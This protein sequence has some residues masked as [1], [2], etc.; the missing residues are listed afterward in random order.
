MTRQLKNS[1]YLILGTTIPAGFG[2]FFWLINTRLFKPSQIGIATMLISAMTL[3]SFLSL[4]GFDT[5]LVRFLWHSKRRN[6]KINTAMAM[7]AI[8]A[9]VLA[10][11]FIASL[12]LT[13]PKLLFM[14]DNPWLMVGFV[15]F[16]VSAAWNVL[17]DAIFLAY[18]QTIYTLVINTFFSFEKMLLPFVLFAFGASGIFAASGLASLTGCLMS[19]GAMI[20]K[21]DY[22]PK[23]TIDRQILS[24]V[25]G[26]STANYIT[27]LC[28]LLPPSVIPFIIAGYL[29]TAKAAYFYIAFTIANLLFAISLSANRS[30]F[31]EGSHASE[32]LR[33][34]VKHAIW[35]ISLLMIP[36]IA[37]VIVL[38]P[39]LLQIFGKSY[40]RDGVGFLRL[41]ALSGIAV[42]AL[43]MIGTIF[44]VKK[45]L[46]PLVV[47]SAVY[48]VTI[49]GG[50]FI[51]LQ[52]GLGLMG[53]GWAW[54]SGN[55]LASCIGF[56]WLVATNKSDVSE[57]EQGRPVIAQ[58][59]SYFPP[60][61]GGMEN[62]AQEISLE[63]VN[64]DWPV[65]VITSNAGAADAQPVEKRDNYLLRRLKSVEFAHTPVMWSLLPKLL[66]L[67][68]KSVIHL[69]I[70]QVITPE[71]V[72]LV[73]KLRR[74]PYVAHFHLDVDPSGPLGFLF[75]IYKKL[76]LGIIL[77]SASRVIVFSREQSSLVQRKYFVEP[78]K[79]AIIPNGVAKHFFNFKPRPI[80]EESLKLLFVGRL[81]AQKRV[82][83][84][85][86][87]LAITGAPVKL[88][89]VGDG[90]ERLNLERQ[91]RRLG[92]KNVTFAGVKAGETLLRFYQEADAFVLP[93]DKEGMPLTLLEAMANGLPV[94]G[95]DILGIREF[96]G[97]SGILA[98]PSAKSFALA[99]E[100][101]W[102]NKERLSS[103]S[104]LS[105]SKA[106][107]YSLNNLTKKLEPL[108]EEVFRKKR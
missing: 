108:Y 10:T 85:L 65:Q 11:G 71:A 74:I 22:K 95:S 25:R 23:F 13:A 15:I 73:H 34:H 38:A 12:S 97:E 101:L 60:H 14:Y 84:L 93:S 4:V 28:A 50:S 18:R 17:T 83:R 99:F 1:L 47:S 82:D 103:L 64:S 24:E 9:A 88:T 62:I 68:K 87:A 79:I 54:L 90:E 59:I 51:A 80:P 45:Q 19:I 30:L 57:P 72:W 66:T 92:L 91:A 48:S 32:H 100:K 102:Q 56:V 58:V 40:A 27:A 52:T 26:F 81:A 89:I 76:F 105:V 78:E 44:E 77:R 61:V 35:F 63:L 75:L 42:S 86:S 55:I 106:K 49:V 36:A 31:A 107:N 21:F 7:V 70:S 41:L 33:A 29:G 53:I 16:C 3:I 104:R 43:G 67:P 2:F 37:L 69:H 98:K 20:K 5:V 6:A 96:I 46:K 39:Y 94:I 8:A